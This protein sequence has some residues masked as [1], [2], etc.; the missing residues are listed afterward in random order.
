MLVAINIAKFDELNN[1]SPSFYPLNFMQNINIDEQLFMHGT[2][3][4][5]YMR[6]VIIAGV[7]IAGI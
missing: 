5:H 4:T 3:I 2:S 7:I 1:N 6:A